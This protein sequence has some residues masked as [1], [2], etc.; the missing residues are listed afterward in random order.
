MGCMLICIVC[1]VWRYILLVRNDYSALQIASN[2][3]TTEHNRSY[4]GYEEIPTRE[5]IDAFNYL[6]TSNTINIFDPKLNKKQF[7]M[8]YSQRYRR[9]TSVDCSAVFN[10]DEREIQRA[11]SMP[12][13]RNNFDKYVNMTDNCESFI[14]SRGYIMHHLTE[15][16]NNFSIAYSILMYRDAEQT[17]RLLRSIYRPQNLYCIHV[18]AKASITVYKALSRVAGCFDN[19]FMAP[20][21]IDVIWGEMSVLLPEI[22]CMQ[23]LWNR[24]KTWKYFI[25]LTGQ[26][27]PLKTNYELVK[28]LKA[29]NGA[30]DVEGSSKRSV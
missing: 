16:E 11:K 22:L 29:Y 26:E 18:D 15:E 24:S 4:Q 10:N 14:K 7:A 9:V 23:K 27:F 6:E 28:I 2:T 3:I 30:N 8:Y 1:Y 20:K 17:E 13:E 5:E 25:N 12:F 21:R 19:V